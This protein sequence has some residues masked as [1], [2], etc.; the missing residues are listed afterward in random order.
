MLCRSTTGCTDEDIRPMTLHEMIS[1]NKE[2]K[3]GINLYL[4][5]NKREKVQS[6]IP[7]NSSLRIL[8][9]YLQATISNKEQ[10]TLLIGPYGKGKSHLLLVLLAILSM[11][12]NKENKKVINSLIKRIGNDDDLNKQVKNDI[13]KAWDAKPF[14]PI[15]LNSTN[16][17]LNQAFLIAL[18]DALLRA[19]LTDL[20]PDTYYSI[21]LQRIAEWE[22]VYPETYERFKEQLASAQTNIDEFI[23]SLK[24]FSSESLEIFKTIYPKITAGSEFNPLA[25]SEV[26][27][28]YKNISEQLVENYGYSGIYIVFDEFSKFVESQ[29]GKPVGNNMGLLQDICELS[30]DSQNAKIF[31]TLIAHKSIKEYG[32][33]L[34]QET[35]NAFTG[36]EGRII[37]KYFVTS[38]K[39]NYELIKNAIIKKDGIDA[40]M[41]NGKAYFN[42]KT[43]EK[44]Y[45]LPAFRSKFQR[46]DF[47]NVILQG[48]FPLNPIAAYLLLNISEKVAQNE[49]TLFTF[50]SNDEPNSLARYVK[51]HKENED[52]IVGADL[53]YD[54]FK[55]LFKKEVTNELI[56]N[57]WLST[58]Y[59][60][61]KCESEDE[62]RIV[63]AL[64]IILAVNKEDELASSEAVLKLAINVDDYETAIEKLRRNM[65][66]YKRRST[67]SYA[68]KTKAGSALKVEIKKQRELKGD[69]VNF[70]AALEKISD[71]N[72]VIPRKYNTDY[73]MTRYFKHEYMNVDTFL[74]INDSRV[75]LDGCLDGKVLK[76]YSFSEFLQEDV[77]RHFEKMACNQLVVVVP[78]E[79]I[80]I[81]KQL[82]DYE[83]LGD[84]RKGN[85]FSGDDEVLR[86]EL[87]I[88]EEDITQEVED[89]LASVYGANSSSE[90][91][92]ID[93]GKMVKSR[94]GTEENAVNICCS[95]LF[96]QCPIINNEIINRE[97]ISS[98]QT[99]KARIN[100]I[101][102]LFTHT[103]TEEFYSGTNQ[104][105]TVYR[106]LFVRTGIKGNVELPD[107]RLLKVI[108]LINAFIDEC[109]D[110]RKSV[111]DIVNKLVSK[112]YGI[113]R[114][115]LPL[116]F[117]YVLSER[118]EDL[119]FYLSGVE[120]QLDPNVI[121]NL[122]E[123][124]EE[125]ELYVSKED[126]EKE[127]YISEL[128]ELFRVG[129]QRNLTDNRIKNI[130][131]CM[132]RWYRSLPQASRN[133]TDIDLLTE[134]ND[135]NGYLR[136]LKNLLQRAEINP[137]EMLFVSLPGLFA[138]TDFALLCE[139]LDAV[140]TA[141][142]DYLDRLV[143]IVT[144]KT[145]E[146]FGGKKKKDLY[147]VLKEWYG[148]QSA[149]SKEGLHDGKITLM[150][151]FMSGLDVYNE[152][153]ISKRL[154]K[155]ITDVYID[156]WLDGAMEDYSSRLA[157]CKASV[158]LIQDE[159][160]E[161]KPKL[162]FRGAN[163]KIIEK[164]YDRA[165]E[166]TGTVLR[167][168]IEDAL[169]EYD[170]LSVNDRVSILL[171]MIERIVG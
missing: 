150:M 72:Y 149:L 28:L 12:R 135:L 130:V 24:L 145:Y 81:K 166:G 106:S 162:T 49:R 38:S 120:V 110:S 40:V 161:E 2:F 26:F 113:R 51:N 94:P 92:Y 128:N 69:N 87:P 108:N 31:I 138:T 66:I 44:Y 139:R 104:E 41:P 42:E 46:E 152:S 122:V 121:V 133:L 148:K 8:D 1:F 123:T 4:S 73:K 168:I 25:V 14:L 86:R 153:E 22:K 71:M 48:C 129:E 89:I 95:N 19:G 170:D 90:V 134:F 119:V 62:R 57:I 165:P 74:S 117:A 164:Y 52:W 82:M 80:S 59:A 154:A 65:V 100:I 29:D 64:A 10:A 11:E 136:G 70:S 159:T 111:K 43:I 75:F 124:P 85:A 6:Y 158:E 3:S 13:E 76:L 7:T 155:V 23:A 109:A 97:S 140:V 147:H 15:V 132:Q 163:G 131:I 54:Y 56:H 99:K 96:R 83:V 151:S 93:S 156:N 67:D 114:G 68:F 112:P 55:G 126:I 101:T 91:L 88:I 103:D 53:I 98:A 78:K 17:D 16:G 27:P 32:K 118:K 79:T 116:Y 105:A 77:E 143:D 30:A 142:E 33:Y 157:S 45:M 146:I 60:L 9:E 160:S 34:S 58:E 36:I 50:I 63:K 115:I 21:A 171:D 141:F 37:E 35:I 84:L 167:N 125:Y 39:N 102:A 137:Y 61:E 47:A 107:K 5:L 144:G 18:N 169:D 20:V 127:K